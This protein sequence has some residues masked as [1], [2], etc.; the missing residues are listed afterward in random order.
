[1]LVVLA[2]GVFVETSAQATTIFDGE[3]YPGVWTLVTNP[4]STI[5]ATE[6]AVHRR[7]AE[8]YS[9]ALLL[10]TAAT[11]FSRTDSGGASETEILNFINTYRP[12]AIPYTS[13]AT[14]NRTG[15]EKFN[16]LEF[17]ENL[18]KSAHAKNISGGSH[19]HPV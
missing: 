14:A 11:P 7:G 12:P 8:V 19:R 3:N 1:M 10:E 4:D 15:R 9:R 5:T 18:V 6:A 16:C 13:E 17:A 2:T